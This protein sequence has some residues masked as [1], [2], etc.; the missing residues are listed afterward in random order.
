MESNPLLMKNLELQAR[1]IRWAEL[2][3]SVCLLGFLL[4]AW[5]QDPSINPNFPADTNVSLGATVSF[6]VYAS[7][8]N[9]PI[10]YQWQRD[11]LDLPGATNYFLT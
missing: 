3:L 10:T 4:P 5:G 8:T 1:R 2:A 7:S 6:R 9:P 11:N